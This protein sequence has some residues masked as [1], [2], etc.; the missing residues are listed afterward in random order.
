MYCIKRMA[1]SFVNKLKLSVVLIGSREIPSFLSSN[2]EVSQF[3]L[4][5]WATNVKCRQFSRGMKLQIKSVVLTSNSFERPAFTSP[6]T[7]EA[8][9]GPLY[10]I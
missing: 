1:V 6:Q 10:Q 5:G 3:S 4:F 9:I 8:A 2:A 7:K